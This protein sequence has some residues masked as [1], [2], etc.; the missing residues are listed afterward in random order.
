MTDP[1]DAK[2]TFLVQRLTGRFGRPP[3]DDEVI[4][5]VNGSDEE[6]LAIWNKEKKR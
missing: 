3:T 4:E 1:V 2:L 6:R 5:F